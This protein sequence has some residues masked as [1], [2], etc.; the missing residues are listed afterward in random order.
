MC[1]TTGSIVFY[2]CLIQF[3]SGEEHVAVLLEDDEPEIQSDLCSAA[4]DSQ[5]PV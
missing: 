3:L 1:R 2:F 5:Y 4:S